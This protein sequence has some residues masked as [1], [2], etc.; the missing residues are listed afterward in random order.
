MQYGGSGGSKG[1][2]RVAPPRDAQTDSNGLE[3]IETLTV[4]FIYKKTP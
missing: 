3:T 4:Q 1:P 2:P